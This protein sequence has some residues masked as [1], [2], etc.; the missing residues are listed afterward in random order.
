METEQD[1]WKEAIKNDI[2]ELRA[3]QKNI[4]K[5]VD[6][7]KINDKLQDQQINSIKDDLREIKGDTKW[8]RHTITS[9]IIVALI[10]G[11]VAIFYAAITNHH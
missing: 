4:K 3:E 9:A 2:E 5:D 10:G 6:D 11:A 1:L 8:L 7:L